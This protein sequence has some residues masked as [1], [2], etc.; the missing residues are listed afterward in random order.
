LQRIG[1]AAAYRGKGGGYEFAVVVEVHGRSVLGTALSAADAER[2]SNK[3]A[4]RPVS[5]NDQ[6]T[7][8]SIN[9]PVIVSGK[10]TNL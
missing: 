8:Q 2:V 5:W 4:W 3:H 7:L 6:A 1:V 10:L 9:G